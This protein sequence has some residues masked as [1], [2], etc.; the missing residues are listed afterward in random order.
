MVTLETFFVKRSEF[1]LMKCEIMMDLWAVKRS[2][3]LAKGHQTA[4]HFT[5]GLIVNLTQSK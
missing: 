1:L 3:K 2:F 5:H 4:R